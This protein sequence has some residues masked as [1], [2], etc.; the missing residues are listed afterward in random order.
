M[1]VHTKVNEPL[2]QSSWEAEIHLQIALKQ[3]RG[4][5]VARERYK[6][7]GERPGI[8]K[9]PCQAKQ[10]HQRKLHVSGALED[11]CVGLDKGEHR[12][13]GPPSA[14]CSAIQAGAAIFNGQAFNARMPTEGPS[15][16]VT[17]GTG[18]TSLVLSSLQLP[19]WGPFC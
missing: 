8:Q 5:P 9:G 19:G 13:N 12:I 16:L 7:Q 15:R 2:L 4:W 18:L 17:D 11:G 6:Q 10:T 14:G 3:S 1:G